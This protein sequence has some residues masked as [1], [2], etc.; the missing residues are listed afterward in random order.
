MPSRLEPFG[1]VALEAWR[2]GTAVVATDR[3]G[4]PEFIR[5][6]V[7][8]LLVDP[9]DT[10]AVATVLGRVLGDDPL[11]RSLAANGRARVEEFDWPRIAEE[12]RR[13]YATVVPDDRRRE[14]VAS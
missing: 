1:I 2:A 4:A 10:A 8:G 5:D 13:V 9:F 6:G 14:R 3:G 7:D 12:Y 11:R